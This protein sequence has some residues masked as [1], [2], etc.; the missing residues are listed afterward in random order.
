MLKNKF[1][2]YFMMSSCPVAVAFVIYG[3]IV[4]IDIQPFKIAWMIVVFLLC[5]VHPIEIVVNSMAIGKKAGVPLP[6]II[7]KTLLFGFTW[8]LPLKLGVFEK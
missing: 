7:I 8:W 1:F 2:W 4:P 5:V 6:V 3:F